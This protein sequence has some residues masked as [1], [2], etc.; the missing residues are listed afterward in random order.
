MTTVRLSDAVIPEVYRSYTALN[1]P[2]KTAFFDAGIIRTSPLFSQ[3]AKA[4]GKTGTI[5]FWLD[6]DQ[7]IEEN[8]SNDDPADIATPN[9]VGSDTMTYRKCWVNQSWSAMDLVVELSGSD[10]M[11]HIR[12]RFGTYWQRRDQRR[13]IATVT[14]IYLDNVASNSSDMIKDISA[15]VGD[16]AKFG[17]EAAIDA[18]YTMGDAVGGFTAVAVHSNIAARMEKNDLID[19]IPDSDGKPVKFYRTMRVILDDSMPKSG[20]GAN[21]IYTS[22]FFGPGAF[23]FAG[24]EGHMFAI[25]EGVPRVPVWIEREEQQGNGGGEETIGERRTILMHPFGFEWV[26]GSLT[27]FSPTNADLALAAHWNR[28]VARKNVPM[29]FLLSKA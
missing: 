6:L 3:I 26:E 13:L 2:E 1:S 22:V 14:G 25:G 27:E 18:E 12:S 28:V 11:Q 16:D 8:Q 17:A 10:P 7:T 24:E 29:A 23:G 5:P 20:S 21:T 9:K 19:V 4:G 15:E